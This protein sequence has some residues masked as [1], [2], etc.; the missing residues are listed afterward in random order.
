M[1]DSVSSEVDQLRRENA[2]LIGLL[3]A[4]GIA[5]RFSEPAPTEPAPRVIGCAENFPQ[6]IALPRGCLEPVQ[7]L[8]KEQGIKLDLLDERQNGSPLELLF[9]GQPHADQEAAVEAMLRHDIGVLQ[10]PTAF[11]KTVVA[12][13]FLARRGVLDPG[14]GEPYPPAPC[15]PRRSADP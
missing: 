11:G 1:A 8:L 7:T 6:H 3:E 14:T 10:A 15:T 5:W 13:G 4:H 12:A 2:R 9:T